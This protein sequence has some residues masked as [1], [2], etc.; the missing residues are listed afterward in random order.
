MNSNNSIS[1][2]NIFDLSLKYDFP[3]WMILRY[4]KFMPN[5][6]LFL[7]HINNQDPSLYI[8]TNTIKITPAALCYR[9]SLKGFRLEK[10]KLK[11]VFLI[12][13][14]PYSVT[15]TSEYLLGYYFLQDL[16]SCLSVDELEICEGLSVLDMASSP[17]GKTTFIAQKMNNSGSILAL[18]PNK[19]RLKR[20]FY[21][22]ERCGV[23]NTCIWNIEGSD[24]L[25]YDLKFDRVLLDAPCSCDGIIQKDI[26][27]KKTY[28]QK[29]IEYCSSKQ[30]ILI[31]TA[32]KVTRPGGLLLYS[33]CSFAPEENEFIINDILS[34]YAVNLEKITY[35]ID[36]LAEFEGINLHKS[37]NRTKRLYPHIHKT[38][39]FFMAKLRKI[40]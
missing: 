35:G 6:E 7:D 27:L 38:N 15:S 19:L 39:G 28:T 29:S 22:L 3:S 11:D 30:N 23:I 2:Q 24:I 33:T 1:S 12:K 13:F 16:S 10:T 9:L 4:S 21:N 18:E 25:N 17:G 20:L 26:N 8:R 14:S 36:G 37:L 34:R 32:I 5:L 31:N 40:S